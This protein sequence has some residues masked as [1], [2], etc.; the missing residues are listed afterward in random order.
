MG[1]L[2]RPARVSGAVVP[3]FPLAP[4]RLLASAGKYPWQRANDERY[5]PGA[6]GNKRMV[7]S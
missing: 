4:L 1:M 2:S 3:F 5:R 6:N 7:L